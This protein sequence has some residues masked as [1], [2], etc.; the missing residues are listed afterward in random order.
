V[1]I[2]HRLV[3]RFQQAESLRR[4]ARFY[5]AAVVGLPFS[6]NEAALFHAVEQAGYVRVVRNHAVTD[7]AAGQAGGLGAAKNTEDIVLSAGKAGG[8]DELLGV[9]AEGVGSLQKGDEDT[10]L[11][12]SW[13]PGRP[14]ARGHDGNYSRY[15]D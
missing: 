15:N 7:A 5:D 6:G 4:N 11:Q 10:A 2:V 13:G 1:K 14:V 9:L 12:G 8:F 3:E